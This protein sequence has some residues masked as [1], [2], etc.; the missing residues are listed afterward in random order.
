MGGFVL[1]CLF[2]H[3]LEPGGEK[4]RRRRGRAAGD[5]MLGQTCCVV[6]CTF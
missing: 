5:G 3:F 6:E 1:K 4:R 2:V